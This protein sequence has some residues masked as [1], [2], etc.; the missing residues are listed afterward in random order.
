[1]AK[2]KIIKTKEGISERN[3]TIKARVVAKTDFA[4]GQIVVSAKKYHRVIPAVLFTPKE[5]ND[6]LEIIDKVEK[7]TNANI[8]YK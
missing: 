5:A 2:I 3:Y 6:L 1:M 7:D 4:N 8:V